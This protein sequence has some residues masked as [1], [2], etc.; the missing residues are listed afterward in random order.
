MP[1][2][3]FCKGGIHL[4]KRTSTD[5]NKA[6]LQKCIAFTRDTRHHLWSHCPLCP[7]NCATCAH[8]R[9]RHISL[10]RG[11]F[12]NSSSYSGTPCPAL[13]G[14]AIS[15]RNRGYCPGHCCI[16]L[17]SK[18]SAHLALY[19]SSMG[20]YNWCHGD[21]GCNQSS[22]VADW[23]WRRC[24]GGIWY[25]AV[26]SPRHRVTIRPVATGNL[27]AYVWGHSYHSC[28]PVPIKVGTCRRGEFLTPTCIQKGNSHS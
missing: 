26:R 11:H 9:F 2:P 15:R 25:S 16:C 7:R 3:L 21:C 1:F 18:N 10:Y 5:S 19:C 14:M 24:L 12:S 4:D 23:T 13:L 27:L 22:I 17:A 20:H 6:T 28:L 8:H